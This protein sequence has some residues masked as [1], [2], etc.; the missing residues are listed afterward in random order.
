MSNSFAL[1]NT[2]THT[3]LR[4]NVAFANPTP[5]CPTDRVALANQTLDLRAAA[6]LKTATECCPRA[7]NEKLLLT[8]AH[9]AAEALE[10]AARARVGDV[11][12]LRCALSHMSSAA[13]A[14]SVFDVESFSSVEFMHK[15]VS[16]DLL[17]L[18]AFCAFIAPM[19]SVFQMRT[20]SC[21]GKRIQ[22][23]Q[24]MVNLWK[25]YPLAAAFGTWVW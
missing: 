3:P 2:R 7:A 15:V 9:G 24:T 10:M 23:S 22:K 11:T 14:C 19:L 5:N 13:P 12:A 6:A 1:Q 25:N 18:L 16:R 4:K 20:T 8:H 21:I 17:Y